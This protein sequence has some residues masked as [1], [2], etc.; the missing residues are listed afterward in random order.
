MTWIRQIDGERMTPRLYPPQKDVL[1][2]MYS[3]RRVPV[4][5]WDSAVGLIPVHHGEPETP[6][7]RV[8][9]VAMVE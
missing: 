2:P 1:F 3:G 5:W 7:D 6:L 9:F 8:A 4:Q